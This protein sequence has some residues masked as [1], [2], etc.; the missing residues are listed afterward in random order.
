MSG[1]LEI[2]HQAKSHLPGEPGVWVFIF[3]DMIV[4][5][6]FFVTFVYYRAQ[7]APL[8][9][10]A[11]STLNQK[12]GVLNT[13]LMLSSSWF[14][15]LAIQAARAR[16]A[17]L[18]PRFFVGAFLCGVGFVVVKV[19][20]YSEKIHAGLTLTTN[21]FYMYYY[22]FTGIHLMHVLIGMTVL[23]YLWNISRT[24]IFTAKNINNLE[25]GASFWHLVDILWI[26]LFALLYLMR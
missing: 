19:F 21:D 5:A 25:S 1:A 22:M 18:S 8:Y 16:L 17:G 14:V 12:Y 2:P 23:A 15:A 9:V 24:A 3:G 10:H 4:F 6:L 26:I 20:E 7:D 11:Q 13:V